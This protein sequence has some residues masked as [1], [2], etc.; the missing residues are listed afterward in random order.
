MEPSLYHLPAGRPQTYYAA[1]LGL[2]FSFCE[3]EAQGGCSPA[4]PFHLDAHLSFV[5]M[6]PQG[7]FLTGQAVKGHTLWAT[8]PNMDP[9]CASSWLCAWEQVS[10]PL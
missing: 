6:T 4:G 2:N 5:L 1:P 10:C 9:V 3:A 8:H 7:P